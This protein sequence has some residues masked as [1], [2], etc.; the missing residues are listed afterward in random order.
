MF[1]SA[2]VFRVIGAV[3]HEKRCDL[4][5][6][7]LIAEMTSINKSRVQISAISNCSRFIRD[8]KPNFSNQFRS[9]STGGADFLLALQFADTF[10]PVRIF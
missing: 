2:T 6:A 7:P 3:N 4:R 9:R 8:K 5:V 10:Y 1:I